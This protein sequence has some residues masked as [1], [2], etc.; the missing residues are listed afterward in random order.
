MVRSGRH[1]LGNYGDDLRS[2]NQRE[3]DRKNGVVRK[4]A[5]E[6]ALDW[7]AAHKA[8]SAGMYVRHSFNSEVSRYIVIDLGSS[9]R[10]RSTWVDRT[11]V[12]LVKPGGL[13]VA[14]AGA[15]VAYKLT[16]P[17]V[18]PMEEI[19]RA[20]RYASAMSAFL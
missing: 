10:E 19:V 18:K 1:G 5:M 16:R 4:T 2:R 14:A 11:C 7:V 13:C 9:V 15:T 12:F 17:G 20:C 8:A 3:E 6:S